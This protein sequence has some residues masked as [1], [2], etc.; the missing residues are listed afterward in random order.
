MIDAAA[1]HQ[2][3]E[4]MTTAV[5]M[6]GC[7]AE[8]RFIVAL[9]SKGMIRTHDIHEIFTGI[10]RAGIQLQSRVEFLFRLIDP[11]L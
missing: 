3:Q 6:T 4:Q 1:R 8:F 11:A 9:S 10:D 7:E 5:M 2:N